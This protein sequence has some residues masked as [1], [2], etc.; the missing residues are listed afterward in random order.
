MINIL[1]ACGC[2]ASSGFIAQSMRK[3]AK[4]KGI[5]AHIRAVS[6]TEVLGVIGDYDALL[7]GPH[8]GYRLTEFQKRFEKENKIIEVMDQ[9]DYAT[10]NGE[11]ILEK[12]LQKMDGRR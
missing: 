1:L 4:A 6:D 10:L 8:I 2:G 3:A 12:I 9:R 5:Q 7:L 11:A